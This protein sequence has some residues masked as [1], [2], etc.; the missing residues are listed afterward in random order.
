[1]STAATTA[2]ARGGAILSWG[3]LLRLSLA[4]TALADVAA[5]TVLGA[6]AW[7][8]GAGAAGP[9]VLMLG[10]ACVYHG[11]MALNDWAD[12]AEDARVRGARP[13]PSGA[14]RPPAALAVA[15][16]LLVLGPALG[17]LAAPASGIALALVAALAAAYD[18]AGRGALLGPLLL[19]LCRAGNLSAGVL[20]GLAQPRAEPG[21]RL[22]WLAPLLYGLYVFAVSRLARLEDAPAEARSGAGPRRALA[23]AALLLVALGCLRLVLEPSAVPTRLAL[24]G[25]WTGAVLAVLGSRALLVRALRGELASAGAVMASVGMALRRL[26]VATAALAAQAGS[27]SGLVVAGAILLGYPLAF[28]LRRVFPPT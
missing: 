19:G 1:M 26:L 27:P 23:T 20:L 2:S 6:G 12:R 18:L 14:I 16:V 5:G 22:L 21:L 25:A 9:F 4:P 24:A 28:A 13:L 11:G 17:F 8:G 10:S 3:R 15:A 7:P